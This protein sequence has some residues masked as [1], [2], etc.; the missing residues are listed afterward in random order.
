MGRL[1]KEGGQTGPHKEF[2]FT[3]FGG[4][5]ERKNNDY[6]QMITSADNSL[7]TSWP[8]CEKNGS[9]T[10]ACTGN[11]PFTLLNTTVL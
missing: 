5:Q 3:N 8:R 4:S 2:H 9:I 10:G 11:N 1:E 6:K 7:K